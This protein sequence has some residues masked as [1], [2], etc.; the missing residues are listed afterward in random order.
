MCGSLRKISIGENLLHHWV[1]NH[2]A[3]CAQGKPLYYQGILTMGGM[4]LKIV[5]ITSLTPAG[6]LIYN[7]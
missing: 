2:I 1:S 3:V 7:G 5:V 6:S 4:K